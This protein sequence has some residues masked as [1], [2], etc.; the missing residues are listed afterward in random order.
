MDISTFHKNLRKDPSLGPKL[1]NT[2]LE[3]IANHD[4]TLKSI[5]TL[6]PNAQN[7]ANQKIALSESKIVSKTPFPP[8]HSIPILLKDN[9]T[10]TS[11]PT[12]AG[13]KA[14][15]SLSSKDSKVVSRLKDAGA[16]ILAK[17]N[18]HEFALQGITLS[19]VH[20]QTLN[21]YD[22]SRTPGGSSG[23]TAAALAAG[24]G[25]VGCGTDTVNSLRSPASA[26]GIVGF[27]PTTGRIESESVVP[28]SMTQDTL[29]P[30]GNCVADVR[31]LYGVMAGIEPSTSVG[32]GRIR[33]GV[34]ES[35]FLPDRDAELEILE[36]NRIV[37]D[38]V[39]NALRGIGQDMDIDLVPISPSSHPDWSF[40]T[41]HEKGDTQAF[42]FRQC[43]DAFLQSDT[44]SSP[45]CSLESIARSGEY[46]HEAVTEVFSAGLDDPET[47][48]MTSEAYLSRLQYIELLKESVQ[49]CFDTHRLDAL[50][51]P[52]QRQL[53][54]KTG[55]RKQTGRNGILAAL[56]GR[57]GICIP[58]MYVDFTRFWKILTWSSWSK[59]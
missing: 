54:V 6:N 59:P 49:E 21:P 33:V 40:E 4:Q 12:T 19:S 8:L 10:T 18:L 26:C 15:E 46:S 41:L 9:Y 45:H 58:G 7:E 56:T 1:V 47:Y 51:Y 42:E 5:I 53:P 31:L 2:Y 17:T 48:C 36:E 16:I 29:G 52:H 39:R 35:Y 11:L 27:R 30:M 13:V 14:L 23:G 3:A 57:P 20:G 32:S 38:V 50:A 25:L 28:V 44:V 55:A 37:G 34:L 22:P 43:L 24:F